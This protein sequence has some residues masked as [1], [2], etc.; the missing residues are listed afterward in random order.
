MQ[1]NDSLISTFVLAAHLGLSRSTVRRKAN[2][3]EIPSVRRGRE[4]WFDLDAVRAAL[5]RTS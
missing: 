5:N 3:G 1:D 2:S 4:Y